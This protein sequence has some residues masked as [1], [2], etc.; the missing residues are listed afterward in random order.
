MEVDGLHRCKDVCWKVE[1]GV[2]LT[3]LLAGHLPGTTNRKRNGIQKLDTQN[4]LDTS[5]RK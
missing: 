1:K 4:N 2:E 5:D 3:V